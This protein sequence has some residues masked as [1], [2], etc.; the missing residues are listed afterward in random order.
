MA[1]SS[2]DNFSEKTKSILAARAGHVCSVPGCPQRTSGPSQEANDAVVNLGEAAHIRGAS[3][4]PGSRRYDPSMTSAERRFIGNGIWLCRNHHKL[5]DSDESTHTV[6]Q[7]MRWKLD[8]EARAQ[9]SAGQVQPICYPFQRIRETE[10]LFGLEGVIEH[11]VP[12][13]QEHDSGTVHRSAKLPQVAE[14]LRRQ[15]W[16]WIRGKGA[17]GK[18]TL[19][20]QLALEHERQ[21]KPAYYLDLADLDSKVRVTSTE[22][23]EVVTALAATDVLF[24]VDNVHLEARLGSDLHKHWRSHGRGSSWLMLGRLRELGVDPRGAAR[25]MDHLKS[26]ALELMNTPDDFLGVYRRLVGRQARTVSDPPKDVLSRWHTTFAADLIAFCA[27]V[28]RCLGDLSQG[29]WSLEAADAAAYVRSAYLSGSEKERDNLLRIAAM[30]SLELA[31]EE[32]A[33]DSRSLEEAVQKGYVLRNQLGQSS[34]HYRLVHPSLGDLL[35]FAMGPKLDRT[36]LLAEVAS[37][38]VVNAKQLAGRLETSNRAA[39][40]VAILKG[41]SADREWLAD[42]VMSNALIFAKGTSKRIIHLGLVVPLE[43]DESLVENIPRLVDASHSTP[44]NDLTAFLSYASISLPGM[45]Q[46]LSLELQKSKNSSRL[47]ETALST[48]LGFLVSFLRYASKHLPAVN[49]AL[50]LELQKAENIPQLVETALNTPLNFLA[51]F[52]RYTS[53]QLPDVHK[54]LVSELQK[55]EN[56]SQLAKAAPNAP[57]HILASFLSYISSQLPALHKTLGLEFQKAENIPRLVEAIFNAALGYLTPFLSYALVHLPAVHLALVSEL[58]KAD[59]FPRLVEAALATPLNL[60]TAFLKYAS[61]HLQTVHENF[62]EE[63]QTAESISRL[64]EVALSTPLNDLASFLGYCGGIGGDGAETLP[65][66]KLYSS[67]TNSLL[68]ESCVQRLAHSAARAELNQVVAFLSLPE[69]GRGVLTHIKLDDWCEAE[70]SR[71]GDGSAFRK[72]AWKAGQSGRSDLVAATAASLLASA[73]PEKVMK[74]S[75]IGLLT[76]LLLYGRQGDVHVARRFTESVTTPLRL[77]RH[78]TE[79][80]AGS[81][82]ST[83]FS[84]WSWH[85]QLVRLFHHP[86]LL[87]RLRRDLTELHH[88]EGEGLVGTLRLLGVVDLQRVPLLRLKPRW[89]DRHMLLSGFIEAE[90]RPEMETIE[91]FHIQF[92]LGLRSMARLRE[93]RVEVP[94]KSGKQILE[95]WRKKESETRRQQDFNCWMIAWLEKCNRADWALVS[96]KTRFEENSM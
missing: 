46:A 88:Q 61:A 16:A 89:P 81:I 9:L 40:A 82:A 25:P 71:R 80:Q 21:G 73:D 42:L 31:T 22:I 36:R 15:G 78:Y 32:L 51:N 90:P 87:K 74:G 69:L 47:V 70:V 5:I 45:H 53:S 26:S 76:D 54:A 94:A 56:A 84:V 85:P 50:G 1:S 64:V 13:L 44:I 75:H 72:F 86:E 63:F 92:W 35:L 41:P 28:S 91:S 58:Q 30:S 77:E 2:R 65:F 55:S 34:F 67:L 29:R 96:D 3:A 10:G 37:A 6:E 11:F 33:L 12:T 20:A 52:L 66:T 83:L 19:A 43:L 17:T 4:G 57:L 60:L 79:A 48:P 8:A 93:D 49:S 14:F 23:F 24:V 18:T 68:K 7:L 38:S 62:G 39:E 27:A 95:L 59:N